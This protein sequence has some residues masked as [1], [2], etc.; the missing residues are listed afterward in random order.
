M[1]ELARRLALDESLDAVF[2]SWVKE[3]SDV[4]E[5]DV[6]RSRESG[7]IRYT[8]SRSD[9][10][11]LRRRA[12][13]A[14][15]RLQ[16]LD[17]VPRAGRHLAR[18]RH[19]LERILVG[20]PSPLP[21]RSGDVL[22]VVW[23]EWWDP[24][25]ISFVLDRV[26]AG[27]RLVQVVHDLGPVTH[28]HLAGNSADSFV[29]YFE[30]ILPVA[31]LLLCVSENTRAELLAWG[32]TLGHSA[33]PTGV[34]RE[35]DSYAGDTGVSPTAPAL[36]R[37]GDEG[38]V[39]SVGTIEAKKNHALLYYVYK[40]AARRRIDLPPIVIVGRRGWRT[41]DTYGL[42][43][44]D[45]EVV[46]KILFLHDASDSELSWLYDH[47]LYTVFPSFFEG[48]GIPIAE[49]LARGIPCLCS[50]A[51]SMTEIAP[52]TAIH[53]EPAS[54]EEL[55]GL[56]S[57]LTDPVELQH[58]RSRAGTYVATTWDASYAQFRDLV[59]ALVPLPAGG[60]TEAP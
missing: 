27:V 34:F 20:S 13:A 36:G 48:W 39:L 58:A 43:T 17:R 45:P 7:G 10:S 24:N 12:V 37:L 1:D 28:P 29:P 8:A 33:L 30:G 52:H 31:T 60:G 55:L 4:A 49:S 38:F 47:C 22:T 18:V 14:L 2:V 56:M 11:T 59:E 54:P 19:R 32:A 6:R 35:G 40:L 23:G 41:D 3:I 50:N 25:F 21:L 26:A 46:E 44:E 16:L 57:M 15:H 5:V 42:M 53:F 9:L 51:A